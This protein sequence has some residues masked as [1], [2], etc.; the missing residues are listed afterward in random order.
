MELLEGKLRTS[1]TLNSLDK[2]DRDSI[3]DWVGNRLSARRLSLPSILDDLESD[4]DRQSSNPSILVD[5]NTDEVSRYHDNVFEVLEAGKM[6]ESNKDLE[7][8]VS[9]NEG[10]LD[11]PP[12][13]RIEGVRP[14]SVMSAITIMS[15]GL[16]SIPPPPFELKEMKIPGRG[17]T[18]VKMNANLAPLQKKKQR[19]WEVSDTKLVRQSSRNNVRKSSINNVTQKFKERL[20]KLS[21]RRRSDM[22]EEEKEY[23]REYH[24]EML[25]GEERGVE[26]H[27]TGFKMKLSNKKRPSFMDMLRKK[28]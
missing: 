6:P 26:S 3:L 25:N 5:T 22:T 8:A 14:K 13:P 20:R 1:K 16:E 28:Q 18:T 21:G 7:N 12:T 17:M 19:Y 10:D 23:F 9:Q 11:L 15:E 4:A 2:K 24:P 27:G